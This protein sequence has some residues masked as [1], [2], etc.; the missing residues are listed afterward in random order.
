[1]IVFRNGDTSR[2]N[3]AGVLIAEQ[4]QHF[5][6]SALGCDETVVEVG[7]GT[8]PNED[9]IPKYDGLPGLRRTHCFPDVI[10]R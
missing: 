2:R 7:L 1:M 6:E 10:C 3:I 5:T 4:P 9:F 8:V